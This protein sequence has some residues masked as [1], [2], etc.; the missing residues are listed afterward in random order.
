MD[1]LALRLPVAW[2][3]ALLGL[4]IAALALWAMALRAEFQRSD[5]SFLTYLKSRPGPRCLVYFLGF[6][7]TLFIGLAYFKLY[8]L[9]THAPVVFAIGTCLWILLHGGTM[10]LF[11]RAA[12]R[13]GMQPVL[14]YARELVG[15]QKNR[16]GLQVV[17]DQNSR[18]HPENT[19]STDNTDRQE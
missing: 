19:V 5:M 1:E 10:F 11:M 7:V 18:A 3:W 9:P 14:D 13:G 17:I 6:P 4:G 12:T 2:W 16:R 8:E 15:L